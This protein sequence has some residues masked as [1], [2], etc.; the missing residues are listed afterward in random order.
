MTL[1]NQT[2]FKYYLPNLAKVSS[3]KIAGPN[4]VYAFYVPSPSHSP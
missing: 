4:S 1:L 2:P 3:F